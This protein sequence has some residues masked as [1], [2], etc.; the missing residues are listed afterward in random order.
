MENPKQKFNVKKLQHFIRQT[1][2]EFFI[3]LLEDH[4]EEK[5]ERQ[6]V[7]QQLQQALV[8]QKLV[9]LQVV[10][11]DKPSE[12]ENVAGF[13]MS[14][15]FQQGSLLLRPLKETEALRLIPLKAIKKVG[16]L[17]HKKS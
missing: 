7:L 1:S 12:V 4:P 2:K 13:I 10:K 3:F 9:V 16:M 6:V 14:K 11:N 15:N 17:S 8:E 5:K